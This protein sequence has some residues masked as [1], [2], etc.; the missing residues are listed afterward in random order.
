MHMFF[1]YIILYACM[2]VTH[3][4]VHTEI[5]L[6]LLTITYDSYYNNLEI[7]LIFRNGYSKVEDT[8]RGMAD[9]V[10]W[11]HKGR[12]CTFTDLL[13]WLPR[14]KTNLL[15]TNWTA[16]SYTMHKGILHTK[17][18]VFFSTASG[19]DIIWQLFQHELLLIS[20]V[21]I[22]WVAIPQNWK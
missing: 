7:G 14:C 1:M 9:M 17:F 11:C 6:R 15:C 2:L 4:I 16:C 21:H 12:H 13:Y 5:V 19:Y 8:A 10:L 3:C 18:H 20:Y 22:D